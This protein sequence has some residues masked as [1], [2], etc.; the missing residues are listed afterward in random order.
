MSRQ[1]TAHRK[2]SSGR[3]GDSEA[4]ASGRAEAPGSG[5]TEQLQTVLPEFTG[6]PHP[7]SE[8]SQGK[9]AAPDPQGSGH[10]G[11]KASQSAAAQHA[12]AKQ[13]AARHRGAKGPALQGPPSK[14]H[15]RKTKE[16][17]QPEPTPDPE[18]E[19][20]NKNKRKA[21]GGRKEKTVFHEK[22]EVKDRIMGHSR[23]GLSAA[24]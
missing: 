4:A 23:M 20:Q 15:T 16:E 6:S 14:L 9:P 22:S 3:A 10:D 13:R 19:L 24:S 5:P 1:P 11:A 17:Q 7:Q 12:E 2:A 18:M 8:G 21:A